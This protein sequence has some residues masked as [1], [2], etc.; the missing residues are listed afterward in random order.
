M[1]FISI[2]FAVFFITFVV[3]Y[4]F[5][6]HWFGK[7][8]LAIQ[9]MILFIGSLG[10][11]TFSDCRFL[12]FLLYCIIISYLAGLIL[13][14][15]K[16]KAFFLLFLVAELIPLISVKYI[17]LFF[18]VHWLFPLGISFFTLQGI[19]YISDSYTNKI[20]AERNILTFSLFI[21][22]FPVISSGPI[23]RPEKLIPQF[24]CVHH[25]EYE[26]ATDGMKLFAWGMLKKLVIADRIAC[27]VNYVYGS[28][29]NQ[30]GLALLLATVLYSFQIYCDF[31]GYSDMAI[32]TSRYLGF[33]L[34]KNFDHPY[35][36]QSVGEFWRRWHISL[37]SWLRDYVYIPLGGSRVI[38]PR[39]YLN[40]VITFLV[41]GLWH[42]STL[43]FAI[44]GLLH[45]IFVC[46]GRSV[47]TDFSKG[48]KIVGTFMLVTFAWIF[49]R[50]ANLHE[51]LEII[52]KMMNIPFEIVQFFELK[53]ALGTK[54]AV[55]ALFALISESNMGLKE[56]AEI[57]FLLAVLLV[58]ELMTFRKNG[59]EIIKTKKTDIRWLFY[60]LCMLALLKTLPLKLTFE[61]EQKSY[62][63]NFIYQNF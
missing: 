25:F 21:V 48:F 15:K 5:L 14:R 4:H 16:S 35:F 37:S 43:N 45:G 47:R 46:A 12:P 50:A 28:V 17:P 20:N 61:E 29:G 13:Y 9:K 63:T 27:Y 32:G 23:Q 6:P 8:A 31:S 19:S 60:I 40:T 52:K 38:L 34:G 26:N 58:I 22:F 59:L 33:D 56:I 44:W 41:S 42:G 62:S 57:F 39:I 51:S 11:Y 2:P 10:F 54:S 30:Y 3:M 49:F 1:S 53:A 7:K 36:S 55:R 18:H 24:Q